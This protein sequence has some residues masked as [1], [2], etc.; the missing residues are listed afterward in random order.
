[1]RIGLTLSLMDSVWLVAPAAS[2]LLSVRLRRRFDG[3]LDRQ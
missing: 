3:A 2:W 1:V